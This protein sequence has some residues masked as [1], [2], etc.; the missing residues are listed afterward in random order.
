MFV[1]PCKNKDG[2]DNDDAN[3]VHSPLYITSPDTQ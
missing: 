3:K 2:D 1:L